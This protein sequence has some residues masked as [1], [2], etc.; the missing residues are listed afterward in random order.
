MTWRGLADRIRCRLFRSNSSCCMMDLR[1][2]QL[3]RGFPVLP[4]APGLSPELSVTA[5][6]AD[7][8]V[9]EVSEFS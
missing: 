3:L 9:A 4:E 1:N 5:G 8:A 2:R 7:S 6:T